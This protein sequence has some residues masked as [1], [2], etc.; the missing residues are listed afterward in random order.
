MDECMHEKHPLSFLQKMEC[1]APIRYVRNR[2][3]TLFGPRRFLSFD[4]FESLIEGSLDQDLLVEKI[5][6]SL[7]R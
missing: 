3:P 6:R 7:A 5:C 1:L 4:R 2:C